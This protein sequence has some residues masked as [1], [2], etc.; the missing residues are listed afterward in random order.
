M[1]YFYLIPGYKFPL[2]FTPGGGFACVYLSSCVSGTSPSHWLA[3]SSPPQI[4]SSPPLFTVYGRLSRHDGLFSPESGAC[5]AAKLN[6]YWVIS[7]A[8]ETLFQAMWVGSAAVETLFQV[9]CA[10]STTAVLKHHSPC[11]LESCQHPVVEVWDFIP[12]NTIVFTWDTCPFGMFHVDKQSA[13]S[14]A[15]WDGATAWGQHRAGHRTHGLLFPSLCGW[16]LTLGLGDETSTF[17]IYS[18]NIFRS[19]WGVQFCLSS[20]AQN[21]N[22]LTGSSVLMAPWDEFKKNT[23]QMLYQ[24]PRWRRVMG[25]HV[26]AVTASV[27]GCP[28]LHVTHF[29]L[30]M[31]LYICKM[32]V[33]LGMRGSFTIKRKVGHSTLC[34]I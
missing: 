31:Y 3:V 33:G 16:F 17:D 10:L 14:S 21:S 24:Y 27:G 7:T 4:V 30:Y 18:T 26:R 28:G 25:L 5:W 13:L 2:M 1:N 12:C 22:H 20:Y 34:L 9:T 6:M 19:R 23:L 8:V 15:S 29:Y 11:L 32:C